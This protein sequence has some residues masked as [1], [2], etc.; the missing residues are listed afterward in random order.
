MAY[1]YT[2]DERRIFNKKKTYITWI[3]SQERNRKKKK[4]L[5]QWMNEKCSVFSNDDSKSIPY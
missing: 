5:Q 3:L 2:Y 1:N 4:D